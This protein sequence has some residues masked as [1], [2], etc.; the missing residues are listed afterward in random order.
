M[1]VPVLQVHLP[2]SPLGLQPLATVHHEP[3]PE[4]SSTTLRLSN[5]QGCLRSAL[6]LL[7]A[8]HNWKKSQ[9]E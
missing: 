1:C 5:S 4:Q 6:I 9:Q 7:G 3:K 2:S 8:S